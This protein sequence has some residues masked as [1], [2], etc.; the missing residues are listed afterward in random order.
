MSESA[1]EREGVRLDKW[2]WAARFFKTRTLAAEAIGGG[3]VDVEGK[4][5]KRSTLLRPGDR[6]HLRQGPYE[7]HLVV[8]ALSERRGTA[9]RSSAS[10]R[11]QG[12]G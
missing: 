4:R 10:R 1:P 8:R 6:I 9:A 5:A 11:R 7:H 12:D 3:K 2:L